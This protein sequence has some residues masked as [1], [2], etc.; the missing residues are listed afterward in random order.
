MKN[1]LKIVLKKILELFGLSYQLEY[2]SIKRNEQ[3]L[4]NPIQNVYEGLIFKDMKI[5]DVGANLGHYT[6]VFLDLGAHVVAFEP[7]SY[8]QKILLKRFNQNSRFILCPFALGS[9]ERTG[10]ISISESHTI[11]SM[12]PK[13]IDGVKSSNRFVKEHWNTT[14]AVK[15]KV[16]E[17]VIRD[18]FLPDYLKIDVEGYELEVLKGLSTPIKFISFEITLPEAKGAAL[19]CLEHIENFAIYEFSILSEQVS[20]DQTHWMNLSEMKH[21]LEQLAN[22]G[23]MISTDV[24]CRKL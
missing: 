11:S 8:C 16:I 13:W 12:N 3:E 21:Y 17:D 15:I 5:F 22:N 7:Q 6:K 19:A 23:G 1:L 10:S 18:T 24:F 4:I 2:W 20:N 9:S 14:E